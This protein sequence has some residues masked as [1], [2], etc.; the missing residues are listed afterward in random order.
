MDMQLCIFNWDDITLM[1]QPQVLREYADKL[2]DLFVNSPL[3]QL[4]D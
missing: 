3:L 2:R 1:Q 4:Q